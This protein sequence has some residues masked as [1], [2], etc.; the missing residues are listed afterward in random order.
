MRSTGS[1]S[2]AH[3][4][5]SFVNHTFKKSK[6]TTIPDLIT[7]NPE[8]FTKSAVADLEKA[9]VLNQ[10]FAG[11]T[12]LA[13]SDKPV[14]DVSV[15]SLDDDFLT[16]IETTS[17][18]VYDALIALKLNKA[19]GPD[20][21]PPRLLAL[22]AKGLSSSLCALF[23]RSLREGKLPMEW[24][25]ATA[26]PVFKRGDRSKTTNYRPISLLCIVSKVLEK[27]VSHRLAPF[28]QPLISSRQSG[29]QKHDGTVFQLLWLVQRWSEALDASE[30][31]GVIFLDLKKSIRQG[32][33]CWLISQASRSWC[34]WAASCLAD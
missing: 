13:G 34:S 27:L 22:C 25:T 15:S 30:Q 11:Q 23:N 19:C 14:P 21:I 32:V 16:F 10:F 4:F 1:S 17:A 2:P 7:S 26:V 24:K 5:W 20:G 3:R 18:Q 31:V 28:L 6:S 12:I 33:A 9:N 29:F 8:G